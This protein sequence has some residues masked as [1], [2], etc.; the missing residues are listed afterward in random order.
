MFPISW[1]IDVDSASASSTHTALIHRAY[2][3]QNRGLRYS[4]PCKQGF[5]PYN[6]E[7]AQHQ[8]YTLDTQV[9]DPG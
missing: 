5:A 6:R 4:G 1:I 8:I 3:I 2:D 7:H 9:T